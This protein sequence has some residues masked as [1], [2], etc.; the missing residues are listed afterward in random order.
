MPLLVKAMALEE[1]LVVIS[2]VIPLAV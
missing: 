2:R 1:I